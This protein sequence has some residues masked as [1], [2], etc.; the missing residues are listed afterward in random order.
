MSLQLHRI[1]EQAA[2]LHGRDPTDPVEDQMSWAGDTSLFPGA[3]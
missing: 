1:M 2:N 3:P